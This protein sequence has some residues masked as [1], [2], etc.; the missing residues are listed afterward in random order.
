M[1]LY[2]VLDLFFNKIQHYI[3]RQSRVKSFII[4]SPVLVGLIFMLFFSCSDNDKQKKIVASDE[5]YVGSESCRE[6]H[7]NFYQLWSPSHHGKAMQPVN[8]QFVANEVLAS[9]EWQGVEN[10]EFR[11]L[12]NNGKL[13]FEE[14]IGKKVTKHEAVHA[15]GGK[16]IY[17]F[18][19][20]LDKGKLQV[21]PLAFDIKRK[22]WYNTSQSA[23]R[24]F[25]EVEDEALPWKH[26]L[27]TFNT[28]CHSCHVSQLENN[29]DLKTK[30]YFTTWKE[31]GI[32]CEACHGPSHEHVKIFQNLK[33]GEEAPEDIGLI[34]TKDFNK[35]QHNATCSSCHAKM[36]SITPS[37]M[38]GDEF[39]DHF[40]LVTL[41]NI[42]YYP[43][44][45]DLGENY[46]FTSWSQS[47]CVQAGAEF[48]CVTCHTSS[49]R[50][51][52]KNENP[53]NACMPCHQSKVKDIQ[54]HSHHPADSEAGK[55]ISCHMPMTEFARMERSD[56]SMRQPMPA[57]TIEF[58]SPN[59]CNIC[60][61]DKDAKWADKEVRKW[62]K[63]DYQA[64]V[65]YIGKLIKAARLDDFSRVD[66]MLKYIQENGEKEVYVASLIRLLARTEHEG[67][68]AVIKD[69]LLSNKSPLVRACAAEGLGLRIDDINKK[70]LINALKDK[71][72]AVRTAAIASLSSFP[73]NQLTEAERAIIAPLLKEYEN[74]LVVR[75]DEWSAYYNLGNF[76]SQQGKL[77][78]AL[79]SYNV[80]TELNDEAV[81]PLVNAGYAYS[82]RGD[83]L[84]AENKFKQALQIDPDNEA[85]NLNYALLLGETNRID[86]AEV[87][88][89]KLLSINPQSVVAA[90]NLSVIVS[91]R[92]IYEALQL[93]KLAAKNAPENGR[94]RYTYAFFLNQAGE[95]AEAEKELI[96]LIDDIPEYADAY[97]FLA[98]Y[99][100]KSGKKAKAI[101]V[102]NRA[103]NE[104]TV[105]ESH[106][107]AFRQ[108]IQQ[109][110]GH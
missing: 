54:A 40:N 21:L 79:E 34:V 68:W 103:L 57:A 4:L 8:E 32:N 98:D 41:D 55:C 22:E 3:M 51:R 95:P 38:P 15:L 30:T 48:H 82:L 52:F 56:H 43:D 75:I 16:N 76:Y 49:G 60:H 39:Y 93:I 110:S 25:A 17:Y 2:I 74:S 78:K 106:K 102:Y 90:Y 72:R 73:Q 61:E 5:G 27:Y 59:A 104:K 99:Y 64:P 44:G 13:I 11:I 91:K 46:T 81:P 101:E 29:F 6:C 92:D 69:A 65:I 24:H 20:P 10:G 70:A 85:V 66:D 28:T 97:G 94:Y 77:D 45:R 47:P 80:S 86:E 26:Y 63:R 36:T 18:L 83:Y 14:R 67:K 96:K 50:Y 89:R 7:E 58:G 1:L 37:F 88:F 105:P 12:K 35:E 109:L 23:M 71:Y 84:T 108:I 87:V 100:M 9:E 42:D 107:Q 62:H 19:T 53:N 33:E 31:P